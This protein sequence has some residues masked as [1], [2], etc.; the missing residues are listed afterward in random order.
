MW[1]AFE[2]IAVPTM[3]ADF[4]PL[5]IGEH[6]GAEART[7]VRMLPVALASIGAGLDRN[8]ILFG[9]LVLG[10]RGLASLV[11]ALLRW[12]PSDRCLTRR[13]ASS[14][15]PCCSASW[16]MASA[17]RRWRPATGAPLPQPGRSPAAR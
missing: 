1:L 9:G 6:G 16:P 4:V 13:W 8:T 5:S 7:V 10:P 12:K 14:W 2:A 11:F 15:R 3:L 17:P